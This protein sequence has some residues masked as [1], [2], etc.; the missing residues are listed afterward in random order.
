[1]AGALIFSYNLAQDGTELLNLV[2]SFVENGN[3]GNQVAINASADITANPDP[4]LIQFTLTYPVQASKSS[5][6]RVLYRQSQTLSSS[7]GYTQP[8]SAAAT[9]T[10]TAK[11]LIQIDGD[12]AH[13]NTTSLTLAFGASGSD[14]LGLAVTEFRDGIS[15]LRNNIT[16]YGNYI[17]TNEEGTST[18]RAMSDID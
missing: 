15:I 13:N 10:L 3:E 16:I 11:I 1:M 6:Q 8:G 12:S 17:E 4:V 14:I 9:T 2:D 18:K 5:V 7:M